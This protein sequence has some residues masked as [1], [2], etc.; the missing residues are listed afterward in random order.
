M[1]VLRTW[2]F[3]PIYRIHCLRYLLTDCSGLNKT[4]AQLTLLT[5]LT[6]GYGNVAVSRRCFSKPKT[7]KQQHALFFCMDLDFCSKVPDLLLYLLTYCSAL[8]ATRFAAQLTLLSYFTAC[9]CSVA[10]QPKQTKQAQQKKPGGVFRFCDLGCCSKIAD[11]LPY[12]LIVR[13]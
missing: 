1:F 10:S 11:L 6:A 9:C 4:E 5:Y 12:L 8:Q 7:E 3:V 2:P 13:S